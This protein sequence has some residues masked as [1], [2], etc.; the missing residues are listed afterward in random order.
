MTKLVASDDESH[1]F[2]DQVPDNVE[3]IETEN[4]LEI[5]QSVLFDEFVTVNVNSFL[6]N[7]MVVPDDSSLC[8]DEDTVELPII[9]PN[10]KDM[11]W[12]EKR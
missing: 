3:Y 1:E 9:L 11:K 7:D 5:D 4:F 12:I 10:P 8:F 6:Q 2:E